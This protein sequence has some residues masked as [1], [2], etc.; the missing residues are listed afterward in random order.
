MKGRIIAD[1]GKIKFAPGSNGQMVIAPSDRAKVI[2]ALQHF[3]RMPDAK[4]SPIRKAIQAFATK[5]DFPTEILQILEKYHAVPDYDL[6]YEQIFDIRDFTSTNEAGFKI[7]DVTS[8]LTFAKVPTGMKAKV[9]KFSGDVTEVTFDMYG[10]GLN[11][12]R[13]LID[14]RQYWT[15]E[16]NAIAFRNKAYSSR[17]ENFY[18]LLEAAGAASGNAQNWA[19]V[20]PASVAASN[21]NYN[22]IRDVNTINAA[23]LAILTDLKDDGVGANANSQFVIVAPVALKSRLERASKLLQQA[24]TGSGE[25][26]NFNIRMIYT[27]M[28]SSNSYYYVCFPKAKCKGGYR[29][30][31]T[32]FD[33][34]DILAYADTMVGWMRYGGA[35]GDTDQIARCAIV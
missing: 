7:L 17:A 29:M 1:W 20:T 32:M 26:L 33:Q 25:H 10:G 4:D 12:D 14:D 24:V 35:V 5:G 2:G 22:A 9:F 31:L 15:L 34:F 27:L 28:L 21:E 3:M 19:A 18:A 11:W 6:G 8:G 30:D 23:C 13:K 16:D